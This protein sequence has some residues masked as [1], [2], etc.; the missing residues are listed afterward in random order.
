M[1]GNK[2]TK[3]WQPAILRRAVKD[4]FLKLNPVN[5]RR[6]LVM[7]LVELTSIVVTVISHTRFVHWR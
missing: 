1:P 2:I 3:L 4:A 6:N 5:Q 7:F